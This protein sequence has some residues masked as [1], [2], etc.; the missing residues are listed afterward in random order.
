MKSDELCTLQEKQAETQAEYDIIR[1][2]SKLLGEY[3]KIVTGK[4]TRA[5]VKQLEAFMDLYASREAQN[6]KDKARVQKTLDA[7]RSKEQEIRKNSRT[8][9]ESIRKRGV[10]VSIVVLADTD[11]EAEL[12]LKYNVYGASWKPHYDIRANVPTDK[13]T[14]PSVRLLYRASITQTTGEDWTDAELTLSTAVPVRGANI[15]SLNPIRLVEKVPIVH[16]GAF[17]T[18]VTRG[19]E[20]S[21]SPRPRRRSRSREYIESDE[22][23]P[24]W[25]N[26]NRSMTPPGSFPPAAT[27]ISP[28][29][30]FKP[31]IVDA[32]KGATST[33]FAI[34]GRSNIP[35]DTNNEGREHTVTISELDF[36]K[37]DLEWIT[38]PKLQ[39]T[40]FLSCKVQNTSEY[41][42]LPGES[43]VFLN[44][45]FVAK[46][47]IPVS[48]KVDTWPSG[49]L[50][51]LSFRPLAPK[52][53]SHV[54]L[55]KT[56]LFA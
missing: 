29:P 26:S 31:R 40:V 17:E 39:S 5:D 6:S 28:A 27:Y 9:E 13:K 41:A 34:A 3:S 11:G 47:S 1:H 36:D 52:R 15:P 21:R 7:L 14:E 35:S 42:L 46:S 16:R 51:L 48:S 2:Q 32:V 33:T 43:S 20:R 50:Y 37:M 25:R 30:F 19:R 12:S 55:V 54:H 4:D 53:G 49:S 8:D 45:S 56:P 10:R 23:R 24:R 44:G 38:V 18:E 22:D